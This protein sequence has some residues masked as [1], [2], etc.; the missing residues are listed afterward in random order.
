MKKY[1][2]L[3]FRKFG[4]RI[5]NFNSPAKAY[6]D[7]VA[8]LKNFLNKPEWIIDIGVADGTPDLTASF[9]LG[10]YKYL[11][12]EAN[13]NFSPY[14]DNIK[15][16]HKDS[17]M[18]EKCFCGED[19]KKISFHIN[20]TGHTASRYSTRGEKESIEVEMKK[21]DSLIEKHFIKGPILLKIDVEGAELDVLKGGIKTLTMCDV[22]ILEAWVNVS[23]DTPSDFASLVKFMKENSFVVF[24]FF[25]GH[26]YSNGVLQHIDIVFVKENS[27]YRQLRK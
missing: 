9:P 21:L 14:L 20:K 11:L 26:N 3:L 1:I 17:V 8:F 10:D 2:K 6:V 13:P 27:E 22:V 16:K 23:V 12:V 19:D 4:K 7:G 25:G 5:A 18:I 15:E 24:D